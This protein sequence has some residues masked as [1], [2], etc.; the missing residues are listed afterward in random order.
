M[1]GWP[2]PSRSSARSSR[3]LQIG[4]GEGGEPARGELDGQRHPVEPAHDV[5][6]HV[7]VGRPD[8]AGRTRAARSRNTSTEGDRAASGRSRARESGAGASRKTCSTASPSG[9]RLVPSTVQS[10]H[11]ASTARTRSRAAS[12]GARSCRSRPAAPVRHR[13]RPSRRRGRRPAA[14]RP[15]RARGQGVRDGGRVGHRREQ[16]HRQRSRPAPAISRAS[17]VLPT[18]PG[19]D[20]RHQPFGR[21]QPVQRARPRPSRPNSRVAGPGRSAIRR[22]ARAT[23]GRPPAMSRSSSPQRRRRVQPGLLGQPAPVL[24]PARSASRGLPAAGERPHLQP[25]RPAPA[26]G[27]RR[28]T[29]PPASSTVSRLPGY[30]RGGDQRVGHLA[31]QLFAASTAAAIGATSARSAEHRPAPQRVR[32]EQRRDAR[33]VEFEP[34][35]RRAAAPGPDVEVQP[36]ERPGVAGS[37]PGA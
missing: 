10:G 19:P 15:G 2:P 29:P 25:A 13:A 7:E 28:A 8:R 12:A 9:S 33:R 26:T 37:P 5:G 20:H 27:P 35:A 23:G 11:P 34:A 32:L 24:P 30:D 3:A 21:E 17:R 16:Q 36:V 14:H 4:Q 18:P 6:D 31:V 22:R 1:L